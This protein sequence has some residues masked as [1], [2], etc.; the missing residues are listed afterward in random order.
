MAS[1]E[2]SKNFR[3]YLLGVLLMAAVIVVGAK[4]FGGGG[5][6]PAPTPSTTASTSQLALID[7]LCAE[8][9]T[10][11]K[12]AADPQKYTN[13]CADAG[14]AWDSDRTELCAAKLKQLGALLQK[15]DLASIPPETIGRACSAKHIEA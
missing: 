3:S 9:G 6:H 5:H 10:K 2:A 14:N 15:A 13:L 1:G 12:H 4:L 7:Q 11:V 8:V